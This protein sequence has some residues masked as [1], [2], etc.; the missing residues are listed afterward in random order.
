M[1]SGNYE[2][3]KESAPKTDHYIL[4]GRSM[5]HRV[6]WKAGNSYGSIAQSYADFTIRHYGLEPVVF[7]GYGGLSIKDNT[8]QRRGMNVNPVVHF[9]EGTEFIGKKE[10]F[11]S[12]ASNKKGLIFLI[13]AQLRKRGCNVSNAP[14][15]AL[16]RRQ[17]TSLIDKVRL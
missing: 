15:V 7:D 6:P 14:V 2:E 16:S 17:W 12:R 3:V 4:D 1:T 5:L 10:R 9:T 11:L 8:H 13:S